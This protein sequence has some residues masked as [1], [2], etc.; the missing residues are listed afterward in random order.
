MVITKKTEGRGRF[1]RWASS[2]TALGSLALITLT[3][4]GAFAY[5]SWQLRQTAIKEGLGVTRLVA[6][7]LENN[8]SQALGALD[9][10]L[11][12]LQDTVALHRLS[13]AQLN[14]ALRI[15]IS[16]MP[17]VRSLSLADEQGRIRFSSEPKNIKAETAPQAAFPQVEHNLIGVRVGVLRS[18]RDWSSEAKRLDT[19]ATPSV[20]DDTFVP[21][22]LPWSSGANKWW[23]VVT[24]NMEH[25]QSQA[26]ILAGDEALNMLWS[27][28]D[29]VPL[30]QEDGPAAPNDARSGLLR[31][32]LST[33]EF[34]T[35][36]SQSVPS[37]PDSLVSFRATNRF[38]LVVSVW[39]P[40]NKA[41]ASWAEDLRERA[42]MLF[43]VLVL[44]LAG[45]WMLLRYR[46]NL[47][48]KQAELDESLYRDQRVVQSSSD[49]ILVTDAQAHI[50]SVN[51]AFEVITGYTASQVLG[52][53]P[54]FLGAGKNDTH[55]FA[56][57]WQQV[58]SQGAWR[59]E[60]LNRRPFGELYTAL[61][62]INA[63][64]NT[65][66]EITQFAGVMTDVT[67]QRKMQSALHESEQRLLM[68]LEGGGLGAW[69]WRISTG[70]LLATT[71]WFSMLGMVARASIAVEE[72]QDLLHPQDRDEVLR[73]FRSHVRQDDHRFNIE[74]RLRHANRHWIWVLVSGQVTQRDE[75]GHV[76][77]MVGTQL[78]ISERK[79]AFEANKLAA[80]VFS[81]AQEAIIITDPSGSMIDVNGAFLAIT[82]YERHEVL[83]QST[84][85]LSSGRQDQAFYREMWDSLKLHGR[86][87]GEIWNRRKSGELFV[88]LLNI[89]AVQDDQGQVL[90][91]VAMFSDITRQ[92]A[93]ESQ[94]ERLAH[95]DA[96]TGLPNRV[97]LTDRLK[98]AMA[99]AERRGT[100][101]AAVFLDLDGFKSVNDKHGHGVGDQLL[102][103]LAQR[104]RSALREGDTLAR[105][106]G[107]EF[108]AVL[109]DL[110]N[111]QD[112]LVVIER[113]R[114]C[115]AQ[116]IHL[117]ELPPLEV[118]ASLG[119]SFY[120]QPQSI[121]ADQLLRQADQAMYQAKL[122]GKNRFHVFDV[123]DDRRMR[124]QQENLATMR[125][126]LELRQFVLYYQPQVNMRTGEVIGVEALVR[127]QH[128]ERGLLSPCHFLPIIEK[129]PL[130]HELGRWVLTEAV[131]QCDLW[132][133]AGLSIR[134]SVNLDAQH[135]QHGDL[136]EEL[137]QLFSK[138]V[139]ISPSDLRLEVLES[140][141]LRDVE[142]ASVV[143]EKCMALGVD[144][145]LDD[146]GTGYSSLTYLRRLPARELKI[147]QSF[148][149][150]MLDDPGD[151]SI[152]QGILGMSQAFRREIVAEGVETLEHGQMLL[153]MG[154]DY[155]QGYAISRPMA[156]SDVPQWCQSWT[157]NSSWLNTQ[158]LSQN[159]IPLL[160]ALTEHRYWVAQLR[161][162]VQGLHPV[163]MPARSS[164][165]CQ[166]GRWLHGLADNHPY[167][168]L[169]EWD[170]IHQFHNALHQ[171]GESIL[172]AAIGEEPNLVKLEEINQRLQRE[173]AAM[174]DLT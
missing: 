58:L 46:L 1:A 49:G 61:L 169:P 9:L 29:G 32:W 52:K 89:S 28:Y 112:C 64:R 127:W 159:D 17:F 3:A 148:V 168:S 156:G 50:L 105:M 30:W 96:L 5:S 31:H 59:G 123:S 153:W 41:L 134:V 47:R 11:I 25:F 98:Q 34:S 110:A 171:V 88:E 128:P 66:G 60:V 26:L 72:W 27:R 149:A 108:V 69:E 33:R 76:T 81:H 15:Q 90:R 133:Q 42:L 67:V 152:L 158:R 117:D 36:E 62:T 22:Y 21:V 106:G 97:L 80:S 23:W 144:F 118:S 92:K 124:D 53:N 54:R 4:L 162:I 100:K 154:C 77:K 68:A 139:N 121:D 7:S 165:E 142:H 87:S 44:L 19:A 167:R 74:Y 160:F 82:G 16:N 111:Q 166:F 155:G 122:S 84:R 2:L 13:G 10:S 161:G 103:V 141:A 129:C 99:Q 101:L 18:G 56:N 75:R 94:L 132:K 145:A 172:D 55:F 102:I 86:W 135:L 163:R 48:L 151:L 65:R 104:M 140:T 91:Y 113:V 45:T 38:P 79:A 174:L 138:Y 24:L 14:T 114:S 78:D 85:M 137:Q 40:K 63:I 35:L 43:P 157:P 109:P 125:R 173:V 147:D 37:Q 95:F 70:Q 143:M 119:L 39:Y 107:D 6:L 126:A 131:S 51:P 146:F 93:H 116:P 83:G 115:A 136:V 20:S 73:K 71:E 170:S 150:G 8:A 120:P 12:P 164:H 130:A 57:V